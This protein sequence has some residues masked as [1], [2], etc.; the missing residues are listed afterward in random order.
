MIITDG[1][2]RLVDETDSVY[3]N[4]SMR[5]HRKGHIHRTR[6]GAVWYVD[7]LYGEE[8]EQQ[9]AYVAGQL[10]DI[11]RPRTDEKCHAQLSSEKAYNILRDYSEFTEKEKVEIC[12][13][14]KD[15]RKRPLEWKSPLHV[16]VY[17]ADKTL[18]HMGAYLDG[19]VSY[20]AGA[21]DLEEL[22]GMEPLE[23]LK[24]YYSMASKKFLEAKFPS[25]CHNLVS[26]QINW[27]NIFLKAMKD[28]QDWCCDMITQIAESAQNGMD[29]DEALTSF[30]P[31]DTLRQLDW[32]M[33]M[34]EYIDG[35]LFG[36]LRRLL[37]R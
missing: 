19:R 21:N 13:A 5:S 15:H 16:S 10:H 4:A 18:E 28:E 33:E 35:S 9:L 11:V 22:D 31:N 14:V 7:H 17:L 25:F 30:Q 27:N 23:W 32:S 1:M 12:E 37:K 29:M 26:Y 3:E 24:E 2:Q 34:K 6:D 8:R 36:T 20:A